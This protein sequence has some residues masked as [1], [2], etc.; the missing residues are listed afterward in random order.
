MIKLKIGNTI[1]NAR[2]AKGL[3]QKKLGE[4]VG[5]HE[6]TVSGWEADR[7]QPSQDQLEALCKYLD[8]DSSAIYGASAHPSSAQELLTYIDSHL[9]ILD[10]R[11]LRLLQLMV[12]LEMMDRHIE[13]VD[14]NV[15]RKN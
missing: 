12:K 13:E 3:T 10:N 2:L 7:T 6:R 11:T 5:A 8:L 14:E 15:D 4:L 9:Y 1:R